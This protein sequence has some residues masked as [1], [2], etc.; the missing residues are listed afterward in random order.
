MKLYKNIASF[1]MHS[2]IEM[3]RK[4]ATKQSWFPSTHKNLKNNFTRICLTG[5]KRFDYEQIPLVW[6]WSSKKTPKHY[7]ENFPC[8]LYIAVMTNICKSSID[9]F[10]FPIITERYQTKQI[11]NSLCFVW[12]RLHF[13]SFGWA[14]LKVFRYASFF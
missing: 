3:R 10:S 13:E 4:G 7:N 9:D 8:F 2:A 14:P 1:H 6:N 12:K 5:L 11:Q